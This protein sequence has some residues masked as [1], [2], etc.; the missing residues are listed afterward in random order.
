MQS[1]N[2]D[3]DPVRATGTVSAEDSRFGGF[4]Q[5]RIVRPHQSMRCYRILLL[6]ALVATAGCGST[7]SPS[8]PSSPVSFSG[9][10]AGDLAFQGTTARMTW[11][12]AQ[13][14]ASVTGPVLIV[15]PSGV[16]LLNGTLSGTV[17]GS[18]L[19]YSIDVRAGG[20]P[21]E[22]GCTGQLGG[23]AA[24]GAIR[25]VLTGSYAVS[26]SPCATSLSNG[27][28]TLTQQ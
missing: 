3:S 20:I 28:F 7:E 25:S 12:L 6:L 14:G 24:I 9:N 11:T 21:S 22:P 26:S 1:E 16:V 19:T 13:N 17:S 5:G 8:A 4:E 18:T 2:S 27:A 15:L 10:W 23:T